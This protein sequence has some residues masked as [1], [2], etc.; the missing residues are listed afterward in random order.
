MCNPYWRPC[1]PR[2]DSSTSAFERAWKA[3]AKLLPPPRVLAHLLAF[4]PVSAQ[5]GHEESEK[6]T[7]HLMI[8]YSAA[9]AGMAMYESLA[10]A[11]TA[12][13]DEETARL[14]RELQSEEKEDHRLA[15][16]QLPRSA[17]V[18]FQTLLTNA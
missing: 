18:A 14:A 8:T 10:A 15:W 13:G 11:A 5:L 1:R 3:S 6:N 4:A 2:L 9:A 12:A 16:E 7:Q 17:R